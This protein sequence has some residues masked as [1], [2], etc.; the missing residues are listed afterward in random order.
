M[1]FSFYISALLIGAGEWFF[2]KYVASTILEKNTKAY[3]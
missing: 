3:S 1:L 2:H